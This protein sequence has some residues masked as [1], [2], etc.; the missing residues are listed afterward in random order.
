[1]LDLVHYPAK[2]LNKRSHRV[3]EFNDSLRDFIAEMHVA[4][5][6]NGG[7]GLAANQVGDSRSIFVAFMPNTGQGYTFIN[8]KIIKMEGTSRMEE[9]CLSFPGR[10]VSLKRPE[11]IV[12]KAQ[13]SRGKFFTM[14]ARGL[15]ARCILHEMDHLN[16]IT[17]LDRQEEA[18]NVKSNRNKVRG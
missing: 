13:D 7:I 9:G 3:T 18:R 17:F 11:K 14:T 1:M 10:T 2:I 6:A 16:G 12:V 5:F 4:M 8:P 15:L